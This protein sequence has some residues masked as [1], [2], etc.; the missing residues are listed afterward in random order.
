MSPPYVVHHGQPRRSLAM[1][2][3]TALPEENVA[4]VE[5]AE[6]PDWV[7]DESALEGVE[8]H[9]ASRADV[10]NVLE[11]TYDAALRFGRGCGMPELCAKIASPEGLHAMLHRWSEYTRGKP[12][13]DEWCDMTRLALVVALLQ[14][15]GR[16]VVPVREL[17]ERCDA[18]A[19]RYYAY[20]AEYGVVDGTAR[21]FCEWLAMPDGVNFPHLPFSEKSLREC[22][23]VIALAMF[24]KVSSD[25]AFETAMSSDVKRELPQKK[26]PPL[27]EGE[28]SPAEMAEA[29]GRLVLAQVRNAQ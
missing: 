24:E 10:L 8:L 18:S 25:P 21:E 20:W 29:F 9:T 3:S 17:Q 14:I 7:V 28:S 26:W 6:P 13:R 23:R 27:V 2:V 22:T 16:D 11:Y 12:P 19:K 15:T 1:G 5:E 4:E